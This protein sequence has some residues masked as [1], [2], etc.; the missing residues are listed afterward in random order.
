[1]KNIFLTKKQVDDLPSLSGNNTGAYGKCYEYKGKV[2]KIFKKD[3]TPSDYQNIKANL[4]RKSDIIMYPVSKVY[5]YDEKLRFKGYTCDKAPGVNLSSARGLIKDGKE[6]ISFDSF[7]KGYYDIFLP[8]LKKEDVILNDIKLGHIF[9]REYFCLVDTDWY[10]QKPSD[11]LDKE[12]DEKNIGKINT[13][14]GNFI[15]SFVPIEV[16]NYLTF[17]VS[18]QE[19]YSEIYIEKIFE[20]IIKATNGEVNSFNEL[21][22]YKFS[23]SEESKKNYNFIRGVL[24]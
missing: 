11:M 12:K 8:K 1:M 7:L 20:G 10:I 24:I 9:F 3:I 18:L 22:N 13:Y 6:D 2:L 23:D 15:F 4:K 5:L 21:Y 19:K 14:L 16:C 17:D